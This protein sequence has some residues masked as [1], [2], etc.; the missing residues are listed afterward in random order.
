M[1]II[2]F[3]AVLMCQY[4]PGKHHSGSVHTFYSRLVVTVMGVLI[5][6]AFDLLF[7]W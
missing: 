7:P 1:S 3:Y 4:S 5:C 6:L 2:T